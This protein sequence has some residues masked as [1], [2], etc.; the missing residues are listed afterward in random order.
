MIKKMKR[1]WMAII[2]A[3]TIGLITGLPHILIPKIIFPEKYDPLQ[4]S[5]GKGS[6]ITME[7]VYTYVPEVR[8]V[9]EEKFWV[10][11]TQVSEYNGQPTPFAGETGLAWIM[12]GLAKL[13]GSIQN[14]F[15]VA[16]FIKL[17]VI[18]MCMTGNNHVSIS[19]L[20]GIHY[21]GKA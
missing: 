7:E 8:E 3:V 20:T 11:D 17:Q 21:A 10:T 12:A 1:Y 16:D 19:A 14:A 4:F 5:Y 6:S 9:L 15:I 2:L 18:F 13:T